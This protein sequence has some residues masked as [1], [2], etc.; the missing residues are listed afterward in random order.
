VRL[1]VSAARLGA[2]NLGL[3]LV[4]GAVL[5]VSLQ[6]RT[7][8][9]QHADLSPA[10]A[11]AAVFAYALIAPLGAAVATVVQFLFGVLS[12]RRRRTVGHRREFYLAGFILVL[13]ALFWFYLAPTWPQFIAAFALL[14]FAMNVAIAP[15]Q[16]A[17][18]DF[19][20]RAQRGLAASWMSV[21]QSIGNAAGL[22]VAG[23]VHDLR[24]AAVALAAPFTASWLVMFAH[25]RR[26]QG[27]VEEQLPQVNPTRALFVLLWSRG[28]VNVGFF[29][30]LGFLLFYVRESLGISGVETQT[31]TALLFLAFT[32]SAAG[33]AALVAGPTDAHDKRLVVTLSCVVI[34]AALAILAG[35]HA[36]PVA[37]AAAVLAGSGWGAF[38]T[39]DYALATTVLPP[40]A[41]AT[42]MGIWNVATTLAQVIAPL[43]AAPLV[44]RFDALSPG[45]GPRAAICVALAEFLVGAALIWRLPRV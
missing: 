17:I 37:Y 36:L 27:V 34:A 28:L 16:A 6:Q 35:A 5:A 9:L 23:F 43:A 3:Q 8:E 24:L 1:A 32:I 19:F 26:L 39:A 7:R 44:L 10:N 18:P 25:V 21:Y 42:S 38:I 22:I 4:W 11:E 2:F 45:L 20:A 13:P 33:G 30:L 15:Y 29:T 31:Q 12:D 41:M 40:G 14:Q